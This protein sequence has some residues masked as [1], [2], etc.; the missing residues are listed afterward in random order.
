MQ[1]E[2]SPLHIESQMVCALGHEYIYNGS[3]PRTRACFR[4]LVCHVLRTRVYWNASLLR[5]NLCRNPC[6]SRIE[7]RF[8]RL[9]LFITHLPLEPVSLQNASLLGKLVSPERVSANLRLTQRNVGI[10]VRRI[11]RRS[12]WTICL[13]GSC[14][15]CMECV[16]SRQKPFLLRTRLCLVK[17][18]STDRNDFLV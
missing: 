16:S 5:T 7:L 12:L 4:L 17:E 10:L 9:S 15:D 13:L 6:L 18:N 11:V 2:I 8:K 3:L 14:L 1:C